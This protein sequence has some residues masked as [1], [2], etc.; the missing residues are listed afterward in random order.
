MQTA[1]RPLGRGERAPDFVLADPNNRLTRFYAH[2][3]ERPAV[4]LFYDAAEVDHLRHFAE[5]LTDGADHTI[6]LFAVQRG[7][8]AM[9]PPV[10]P[11]RVRPCL[12]FADPQGT[13]RTA[14][15]P[16]APDTPRLFV[17]D[18]NLRVLASLVLHD[19]RAT[20]H[21]VRA[22][23]DASLPP[24]APLEI[25]TQAPVL[26]IPDALD[27]ELCQSLIHIWE[28]Q[29][30]VATGVEQSHGARRA[31]T[32]RPDSKRRRDH[33]VREAPLVRHLA[34]TIGR[35]VMPEVAKAFAFR[36]TRFEGFTI[37][38]YDA[39]TGGFFRAHRD[40]LSPATAHRRFALSLNLNAGYEGGYLRFP[41][42][43]PHLYR[44]AAG[45]ALV[46]ACSHLHEVTEVRQG[47]RFV[48][49]SFLFGA[50]ESRPCR[51]RSTESTPP[52]PPSSR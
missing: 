15:C 2:A 14:Y 49:L 41:E 28:T 47:R 48:L 21:Q 27:Q 44:P 3:D 26:L 18:P 23:L 35:R 33:T 9:P 36:A 22:L 17:L 30:H 4:L 51:A 40:N 39:A 19:A 13:V 7:T 32:L 37:A 52:P 50:G 29:G 11:G 38:C 42:Y 20:A 31:A 8:P 1:T 43:G 46:F 24:I 25:T 6:A 45:G 10:V 5:A 34:S 12:V 16:G